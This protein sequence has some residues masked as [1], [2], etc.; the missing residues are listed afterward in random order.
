MGNTFLLDLLSYFETINPI[1]TA[2][3][4]IIVVYSTVLLMFRFFGKEGMY[5]YVAI[6]VITANIQVLKLVSFPILPEPLPLGT[7]VFASTYV[8]S[9][10][11][12]NHY[13]KQEV[14]KLIKI[15]FVSYVIFTLFMS[16][17]LF[18]RPLSVEQISGLAD[19]VSSYSWAL[20]IQDNL[21]AL[22]SPAP[23]LFLSSLAAFAG[24]QLMNALVF[25]RLAVKFKDKFLG[26]RAFCSSAIGN[27][28]DN[29]IFSLCAFWLLAK[30]PMDL[31]VLIGSYVLSLFVFRMLIVLI[32]IPILKLSVK[33]KPMQS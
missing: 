32:E 26:L 25:S 20:G 10:I 29:T 33:I 23:S 1:Y 22:F 27:L 9:D 12:N 2:L 11:V 28:V 17:N 8:A 21:K 30:E 7:V 15:S 13:G 5:I 19:G 31:H 4:E 3:L 6:A 24:S 16:V 18:F 14:F